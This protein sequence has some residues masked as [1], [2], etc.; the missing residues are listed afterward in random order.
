MSSNKKNYKQQFDFAT[1]KD[2]SDRIRKKYIDRVPVIVEK[3]EDNQDIPDIDKQKFLVPND[4]TVGQ[5]IYVIRKRI[6]LEPQKALFCFVKDSTIPSTN[7]IM[8]KV[9]EDNV[10]EDGFLYVSYTGENT[11]G[12]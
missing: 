3:K 1:R 9:Y 5:F 12:C 11:F 6:S 8:S 10:D 2:E 7:S 4:L